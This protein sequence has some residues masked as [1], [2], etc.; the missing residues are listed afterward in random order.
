MAKYN[1]KSKKQNNDKKENTSL[2]EVGIFTFRFDDTGLQNEYIEAY[3]KYK[4]LEI[5]LPT[6]VG[7]NDAKS[8]TKG[9]YNP[10]AK[11]QTKR[12]RT[13]NRKDKLD[14]LLA[15]YEENDFS[16]QS[17]ERHKYGM[18]EKIMDEYKDK[19]FHFQIDKLFEFKQLIDKETAKFGDT[20]KKGST[21][22]RYNIV[23]YTTGN[24]GTNVVV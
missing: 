2:F 14:R 6:T 12:T 22:R 17:G 3:N 16:Y 18:Y 24:E 5:N 10:E 15:F 8:I 19:S 20:T 1:K 4:V 9:T 21:V 13:L 7:Y 11:K 23:W